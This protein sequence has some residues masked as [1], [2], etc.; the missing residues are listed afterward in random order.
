MAGS[1]F[2]GTDH[3]TANDVNADL[4]P[5][6]FGNSNNIIDERGLWPAFAATFVPP[7]TAGPLIYTRTW[8]VVNN[9]LGA[10]TNMKTTAI[11]V[12]WTDRTG[13]THTVTLEGVRVRE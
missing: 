1:A 4:A 6:V 12:T 7:S 13:D 5:A 11:I 10:S 9:G 3:P 2:P 8:N